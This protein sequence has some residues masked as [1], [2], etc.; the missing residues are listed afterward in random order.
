MSSYLLSFTRIAGNKWIELKYC[1]IVT[2]GNLRILVLL[3]IRHIRDKHV[4]WK[5][6]NH[7]LIILF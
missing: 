2:V 4:L 1:G 3:T 6:S 7:L 5:I